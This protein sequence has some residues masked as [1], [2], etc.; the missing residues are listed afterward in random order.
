MPSFQRHATEE[1][2]GQGTATAA[3]LEATASWGSQLDLALDPSHE[4]DV[5]EVDYGEDEDAVSNLLGSEIFINTARKV[6]SVAGCAT[7]AGG[8]GLRR[9]NDKVG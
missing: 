8:G 7:R 5:L 9:V 6:T 2:K 1:G 3:T 4:E